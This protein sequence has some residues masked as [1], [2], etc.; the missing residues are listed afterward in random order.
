MTILFLKYFWVPLIP[1]TAETDSNERI[2]QIVGMS[3]TEGHTEDSYI[4]QDYLVWLLLLSEVMQLVAYRAMKHRN[5]RQYRERMETVQQKSKFF[6]C[7]SYV[8]GLVQTPYLH[9]L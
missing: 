1:F 7:M 3:Y 2:Y 8:Y 5:S 9:L 6:K 4:P